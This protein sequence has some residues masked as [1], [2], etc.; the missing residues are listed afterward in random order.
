MELQQNVGLNVGK[1]LFALQIP[2]L[3]IPFS[4][5]VI[6]EILRQYIARLGVPFFFAA[7]GYLLSK[8]IDNKGSI[9]ALKKYADRIGVLLVIWLVIYCPLYIRN[10]EFLEMPVRFILFKTPGF[11]WYL[12][13]ILFAAIPFCIIKNR[14]VLY[15]IAGALYIIGT[16][17]GSSYSWL[18]D[19]CSVY[20][21]IF[22]TTRN[23]L[24]FA[25]PLMLTGEIVKT[26]IDEPTFSWS[27]TYR[28]GLFCTY[29]V[30][31]AEVYLCRSRVLSDADCSMYFSLPIISFFLLLFFLTHFN[32][33]SEV[34]KY[35]SRFVSKWSS[36]IYLLQ[37]GVIK[38]GGIAL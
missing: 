38:V 1:I 2:F 31:C 28:V 5:N 35:K 33:E 9:S 32:R 6:I 27:V 34:L 26:A 24:F 11:L 36:A 29:I 12:T 25:L 7:S 22:L 18:V 37:Y 23:G 10:S 21:N 4:D 17:M 3:H 13:A 30:F 16:M 19:E 8:S 15:L 14:K 20:S